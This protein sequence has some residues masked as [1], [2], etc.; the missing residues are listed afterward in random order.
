MGARSP[1]EKRR[2]RINTSDWSAERWNGGGQRKMKDIYGSQAEY[3]SDILQLC[4]MRLSRF[5][6]EPATDEQ[7]RT[8]DQGIQRKCERTV[9]QGSGIGLEYLFR[10]FNLTDFER[11]CVMLALAAE[12]SDQYVRF[13]AARQ[14]GVTLPTLGLCLNSFTD[15]QE[16][17]M[18]LLSQWRRNQ[19]QLAYFFDSVLLPEEQE[20]D[21][22]TVLKLSRRMVTFALDYTAEDSELA[23]GGGLFWPDQA[24]ELILR[25]DLL[26][27]MEAYRETSQNQ[28]LFYLWGQF[29]SGRRTLIRTFCAVCGRALVWVDLNILVQQSEDWRHLLLPYFRETV[30]RDA[31]LVVIGFQR[32]QEQ[33]SKSAGHIRMLLKEAALWTDMVFLLSDRPWQPGTPCPIWQRAELHLAMPDA[34]ERQI[35]W[36]AVLRNRWVENHRAPQVLSDKFSLLPG[37]IVAAADKAEQLQLWEGAEQISDEMLHRAC[38]DQ[39]SSQIGT[40]AVRVN[41]AYDWEDLILPAEQKRRL[42]D[43]CN[44]VEY[45]RRVYTEWGF[46]KK[47]AYGRGVSMLFSG[48]PGTGKTMAA[49]VIANRLGL[50]LY[51]VDLSN[52]LSKY[53]GD[54]EK[55]LGAVFDEVR[56]S[57]SILFFDEADALFGKRSE[58]RDSHDRY[59]NVQ[60]SY[61]LQ[62]IEEYDGVVILASNLIQNFDEAFKRRIKFIVEFTLPDCQ[63]REQI[64]MSVMPPQLPLDDDVDFEFLA[65]SFELSG[66]SIKNTAVAAAFLA[67]AEGS[68]VKMVHLLLSVQAEQR[69]AGKSVSRAEFGEYYTQVSHYIQSRGGWTD[70]PDV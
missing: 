1:G 10:I 53:I 29:G 35:L 30:I 3:L 19:R 51:Q 2:R 45:R 68:P 8:V 46:G 70:G 16:D 20:T 11:H 66:S 15:R 22:S 13:L 34:I 28:L 12:L 4:S 17:Q 36:E 21:L 39:L 52:V 33:T 9:D 65:R 26:R 64:W 60:T 63:H 55:Q 31:A 47:I 67:A 59:A 37:Q 57:Q 62:K 48:P 42:M 23:P 54:T 5:T 56:K 69:K 58:V 61:L 40:L 27:Q 18:E 50:E 43:A 7:I 44:Q 24:P 14:N 41:A 32:L 6:E 38:R 49:Q 25:K